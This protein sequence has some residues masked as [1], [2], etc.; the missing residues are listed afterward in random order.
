MHS[1]ERPHDDAPRE[2]QLLASSKRY[3]VVLHGVAVLVD[4][5]PTRHLLQLLGGKC[6]EVFRGG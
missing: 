5:E 4:K 6:G 2:E 3:K 1:A